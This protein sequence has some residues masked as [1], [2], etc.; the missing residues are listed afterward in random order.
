MASIPTW[1]LGKH[2]TSVVLTPQAVAADGTLSDSGSNTAQTVTARVRRIRLN[3][4]VMTEDIRPVNSVRANNVVTGFDHTITLSVLMRPKSTSPAVV[5]SPLASLAYAASDN[6]I[7]KCTFTR[8]TSAWSGY[9]TVADY[10][11]GVESF[12]ANE[13]ELTLRQVDDGTGVAYTP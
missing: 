12:G 7:V 11:E 6:E 4:S 1:L 5:S 2:L 10:T 13:S 9:F 3:S 8:G